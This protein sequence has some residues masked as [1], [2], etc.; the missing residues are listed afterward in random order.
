MRWPLCVCG[1]AIRVSKDDSP[2]GPMATTLV[3]SLPILPLFYLICSKKF[4]LP[5][6][7]KKTCFSSSFFFL[8]LN[9]NNK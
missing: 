7:S 6:F 4:I 8:L 2:K 1:G 3:T 5:L 9:K